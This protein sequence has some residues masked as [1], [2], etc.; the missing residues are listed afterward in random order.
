MILTYMVI[1]SPWIDVF[2]QGTDAQPG[3]PGIGDE[4]FPELGNGGYDVQHYTIDLDVDV[5][6]NTIQGMT[7]I[8]MIATQD[9]SAFNLEFV[10]LSISEVLVNGQRANFSRDGSEMTVT[11]PTAV[12]SEVQFGVAIS[13]SGTPE[14]INHESVGDIPLGWNSIDSGIYVLSEPVGSGTWYPVNDHPLDKATY[15]YVITVSPPYIVA[16]NGILSD[17]F[18][19]EDG[20]MTY[21]FVEN[22]PMA[23]YLSTLNI[24][25]HVLV[26]DVGP[27][28]LPIRSYFPADLAEDAIF[29]FARTP[30][31]IEFFSA[32]FGPYPFDVYG[33][34]VTDANFGYALETQTLSTF[35]RGT[36]DGE[37]TNEDVIA[38]E[39]THQWFGN[40]LSIAQWHD[41]WLNEGFATYGEGLWTE[42][43]DGPDVFAEW[44]D[45]IYQQLSN[46]ATNILIGSP[47]P[48]GIF[49]PE[50]Y[51]RGAL[52]LHALRVEVGDDL[53]FD[54]LRT[55][56]ARYAD[57]NVTTDQFIALASNVSGRDLT[58]LFQA[59]LFDEEI[60]PMPVLE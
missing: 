41:I 10:G 32:I 22:S 35:G 50:V 51:E 15:A 21:V 28:G 7:T 43:I 34:V 2:A 6:N 14:A 11:L 59:W 12:P 18:E 9:L 49:S 36:V 47:P 13:Y 24:A 17:A 1:R 54:I 30:E 45:A 29:D 26:E 23:S 58:A 37:R 40:S 53:F 38:H 20:R 8:T 16:A 42:H 27:N 48:E 52:T 4:L 31:M 46:N 55:Y 60:P 3:A 25:E 5:E 56:T 33:V 44:V 39:L 19:E 57:G